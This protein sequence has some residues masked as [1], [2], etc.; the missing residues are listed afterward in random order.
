MSFSR[1][2][3]ILCECQQDRLEHA[4]NRL[5]CD[6]VLGVCY[7]TTLQINTLTGVGK[8]NK[9][10]NFLVNNHSSV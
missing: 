8:E 10:L 6:W 9:L 7:C 1:G 3:V 4:A 5:K 2:N